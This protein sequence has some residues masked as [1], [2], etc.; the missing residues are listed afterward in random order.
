MRFRRFIVIAMPALLVF[1]GALA[2]PETTKELGSVHPTWARHEQKPG[3]KNFARVSDDLYR[4]AQPSQ[5]G[6]EELKALG[7]KTEINLRDAHSDRKML[8]GTG[9]AYEHIK[10]KTWHPE[11]EEVVRFLKI[12]T[13]EKKGPFFVHCKHGSDR[14]G[15]MCAIYRVAVQGWSKD[16]AIDEMT[17]GDFGFHPLWQN[18]IHYIRDLDIEKIKKEAGI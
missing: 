13:D 17:K 18:L 5:E 7:I 9:I 4:G 1:A 14:T 6:F 12:V 11:D 2:A 3:L 10:F 16:E 8:E 15:M